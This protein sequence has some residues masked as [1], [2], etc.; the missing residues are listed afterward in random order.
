ML[1][2]K[3]I[4]CDYLR[5]CRYLFL[6]RPKQPTGTIRFC[7]RA[8]KFMF[9]YLTLVVSAGFFVHVFVSGE[10][11]F[12]G[13][14][15]R[16]SAWLLEQHILHLH[17]CMHHP[18]LSLFRPSD[19]PPGGLQRRTPNRNCLYSLTAKSSKNRPKLSKSFIK[20]SGLTP[21]LLQAIEVSTKCRVGVQY[22][23]EPA[24]L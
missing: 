1:E 16:V 20:S 21:R 3:A 7:F 15:I 23:W 24:L 14:I 10:L 4:Y 18:T 17:V 9:L 19:H 13:R 22:P 11:I 6:F 5:D 12:S 2:L 8:I